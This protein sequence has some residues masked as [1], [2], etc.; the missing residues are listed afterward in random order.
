MKQFIVDLLLVVLL[1]STSMASVERFARKTATVASPSDPFGF[2]PSCPCIDSSQHLLLASNC[3]RIETNETLSSP[4]I[5]VMGHCYPTNYGA[6]FCSTFD[7]VADPLCQEQDPPAYCHNPWCFVDADKC[8][9]S[10]KLFHKSSFQDEAGFQGLYY[11][12]STCNSSAK[13]WLDFE[14]IEVFDRRNTS[15]VVALPVIFWPVHFKES[16]TGEVATPD[17]PEAYDDS[18]PWKGLFID[19]FDAVV[20][21][22]NIVGVKYVHRSRGSKQYGIDS[23]FTQTVADVEAG[24]ADLST[25]MYWVTPE[26]WA[27]H[28]KS[29]SH[30]NAFVIFV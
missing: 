18:V 13:D 11:S 30:L 19:Y 15:L 8:R 16:A 12:Y 20:A 28:S 5:R 29:R 1:M 10:E 25:S 7:E 27:S 14:T 9:Y 17:G 22:S 6:D 3:K 23:I 4:G 24:V 26:R 2:D 21:N